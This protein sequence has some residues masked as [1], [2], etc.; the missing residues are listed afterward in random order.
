MRFKLLLCVAVLLSSCAQVPVPLLAVNNPY[1]GAMLLRTLP[2]M[3]IP[4]IG[5]EWASISVKRLR[6]TPFEQSSDH[7]LVIKSTGTTRSIIYAGVLPPGTYRLNKLSAHRCTPIC[8]LSEIDIGSRHATFEI[9]SGQLTDLGEWVLEPRSDA[10]LLAPAPHTDSALSA[11]IVRQILPSLVPLLAAPVIEWRADSLV[12]QP[13]QQFESTKRSSYGVVSVKPTDDGRFLYGSANGVVYSWRPGQP[14]Q[15]HDIGSQ[16]SIESVLVI[17]DGSWLAGGELGVVK[18]SDDDG[19]TW[20]SIRGNLPFGVVADLTHWNGKV[21]ATVMSANEVF[22]YAAAPGSDSW[23]PVA[24][25]P[26]DAA[27]TQRPVFPAHS[28]ARGDT[29]FITLPNQKLAQLDLRSG[30]AQ[31]SDFPGTAH[32]FSISPDGVLYSRCTDAVMNP[33]ESRDQG[34]TWKYAS[35]TRNMTVPLWRDSQ[36]AIGFDGGP[37]GPNVIA[38]TDDGGKTWS[39]TEKLQQFIQL[40][41]SQDGKT[42]YA[43]ALGGVFWQSTDDGR[44]WQQVANQ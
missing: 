35:F 13:L 40:F 21:L 23:Q 9:R 34:K 1:D 38:H 27:P 17:P 26:M 11:E 25:F 2:N 30:N 10:M 39:E 32:A 42:A 19:K 5:A 31:M 16:V 20:R 41:Y 8:V 18:R 43:A 12:P 15:P 22:I 36:H 6:T 33:Y 24:R 44:H 4:P 29:L 3:A 7:K 37:F 28:I 14:P